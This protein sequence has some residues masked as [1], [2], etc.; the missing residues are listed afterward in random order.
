MYGGFL[1]DIFLGK[2][3]DDVDFLFRSSGGS[4]IPYLDAVAQTNGWPS[5][6]KRDEVGVPDILRH[7][8]NPSVTLLPGDQE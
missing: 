5:Y 3:A 4:I 1:R 8:H 7:R 6:S 2:A